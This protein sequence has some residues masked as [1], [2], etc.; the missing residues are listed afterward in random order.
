MEVDATQREV[1]LTCGKERKRNRP[2]VKEFFFF[3]TSVSLG[4][5]IPLFPFPPLDSTLGM[6]LWDDFIWLARREGYF[7]VAFGFGPSR[8]HVE[9][10][11]S[12][13]RYVDNNKTIDAGACGNAE[14]YEY[15]LMHQVGTASMPS[16]MQEQIAGL[17]VV[18]QTCRKF[19]PEELIQFN[20]VRLEAV[21]D[22]I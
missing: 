8:I 14:G 5:R 21:H 11:S 19:I 22:E 7:P 1:R 4:D 18:R 10:F 6:M 13:H 17:E 2:E 16:S 20:K 9:G 3:F 12:L 15:E